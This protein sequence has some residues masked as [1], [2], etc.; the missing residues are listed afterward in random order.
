M[1]TKM[2]TADPRRIWYSDADHDLYL[3]LDDGG[4]IEALEF[5]YG[6]RAIEHALLVKHDHVGHMRIDDGEDTGMGHKRSPIHVVNGEVRLSQIAKALR[7]ELA[8]AGIE[9]RNITAFLEK[10]GL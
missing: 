5:C 1:L 9:N 8:V 2:K 6:K 7:H 10:T 3:Y 4:Q